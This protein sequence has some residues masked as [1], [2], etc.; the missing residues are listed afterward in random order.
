MKRLR[1]FASSLRVRAAAAQLIVI[2]LPFIVVGF[3]VDGVMRTSAIERETERLLGEIRGAAS[4][5]D[6]I[7][8]H[9]RAF[10]LEFMA[11]ERLIRSA[12]AVVN[13]D[14]I[15]RSSQI[16]DLYRLYAE[17]TTAVAAGRRVSSVYFYNLSTDAF[18]MRTDREPESEIFPRFNEMVFNVDRIDVR[19]TAWYSDFA[20]KNQNHHWILT[21]P[22]EYDGSYILAFSS[23]V[24][25]A[26]RETFAVLSSNVNEGDLNA[27]LRTAAE[28]SDS[29]AYMIDSDG[30]I[31]STTDRPLLG[32]DAQETRLAPLLPHTPQ[33]VKNEF[34]AVLQSDREQSLAVSHRTDSGWNYVFV[35]P[36]S[37]VMRATWA[38]RS[39]IVVLFL[40]VALF[41]TASMVFA[42]RLWFN[43]I[44]ELV[45]AMRGFR[46]GNFDIRLPHD[47]DDEFG[48]IFA[49]F[50]EMTTSVKTLVHENYEKEIQ[51][52]SATMK[53]V[54]T[55][56]KSHFL[57]NT[58][59]LINWNVLKGNKEKASATLVALSNFYR[60]SLTNGADHIS[61]REAA[62][63]MSLYA[64]IVELRFPNR[65][66]F[67]V[68]YDRA[69]ESVPVLKYVFQPL[70]ENAFVH[71]VAKKGRTVTVL[72]RREG[73]EVLFQ[74]TDD[75]KGIP[76]DQLTRI[77]SSLDDE[78]VGETTDGF[79][80]VSV[81][82]HMKLSYGE[83]HG[84]SIDS[85]WGAGTT[86]TLR[87]P[88][89]M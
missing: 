6:E 57:F 27:I 73:D 37:Y 54:Q 88:V 85:T 18:Y 74:L 41:S 60:M 82:R 69:I 25:L 1:L 9:S 13:P 87:F 79:A 12:T 34:F 2:L 39:V 77:R 7:L 83:P 11:N 48:Y 80:L 4:F 59:D 65:Y 44:K 17:M 38:Y 29:H 42:S 23:L 21:Q 26:Q 66:R 52:K 47:R 70:V 3:I 56:I 15:E 61:V 46:T 8:D 53:H 5:I 20:R 30:Q 28:G 36:Y 14:E 51:R 75:G 24:N 68:A 76:P 71:G 81:N 10:N 32:R 49:Q 50:N 86:V 89:G 40:A 62:E 33:F 16:T 55:Q 84:L 31:V 45:G 58:L 72:F 35:T 63:M 67:T 22:I 19:A 43:P 64:Q 78:T